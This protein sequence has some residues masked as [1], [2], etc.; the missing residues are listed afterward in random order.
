MSVSRGRGVSY[1]AS[2][3]PLTPIDATI[4]NRRPRR[5]EIERWCGSRGACAAPDAVRSR[6]GVAVVVRARPPTP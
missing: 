1:D 3:T 6:G 2:A 4:G 5:R